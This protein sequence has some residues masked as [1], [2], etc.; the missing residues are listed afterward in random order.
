MYRDDALSAL[1]TM[2]SSLDEGDRVRLMACDLNAISMTAGFV[3]AQ[4]PAMDAALQKLRRRAPLGSTD[5]HG[6]L[7]SAAASFDTKTNSGG[8]VI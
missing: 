1:T 5:M 8:S 7:T 4:G 2:L 3:P 6:A